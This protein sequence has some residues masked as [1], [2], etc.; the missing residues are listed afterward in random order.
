MTDDVARA[1]AGVI[2]TITRDFRS[3]ELLKGRNDVY[4]LL[5]RE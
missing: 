5:L 3:R 1:V 4:H 2:S